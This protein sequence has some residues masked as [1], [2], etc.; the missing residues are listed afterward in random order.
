MNHAAVFDATS[1][2][3]YRVEITP[4]TVTYRV[5]AD[6]G[7]GRHAARGEET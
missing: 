2:K 6:C 5:K 3:P 7:L 4:H 1:N